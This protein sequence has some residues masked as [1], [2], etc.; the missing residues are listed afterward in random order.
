[1]EKTVGDIKYKLVSMDP[2]Q[3]E[4]ADCAG[5]SCDRPGLCDALGS[6][7]L[8]FENEDKVW[9]EVKDNG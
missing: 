8:L 9:Q 2:D 5:A 4:C 6:E 3:T 1:M 7:C